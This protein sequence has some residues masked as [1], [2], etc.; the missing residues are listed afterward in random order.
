MRLKGI[1][2]S[3]GIAIAPAFVY[4]AVDLIVRRRRAQDSAAEWA[5]FE[6]AASTALRELASLRARAT[7]EVGEAEAA[8]F[9]AHEMILRDPEL[10]G[11]L[12]AEL[13]HGASIEAAVEVVFAQDVATFE[14]MED[15]LFRERAADFADVGR[16]VLRILLGINEDPLSGMNAPAVIVAQDLLP[17]DT[18]RLNKFLTRGFCTAAGGPLSHTAILARNLG[19]PAVVGVGSAVLEIGDGQQLIADGSEG[20][21]VVEASEAE[22]AAYLARLSDMAAARR[23]ALANALA[24]AITR[25][26]RRAEVV[27]NVGFPGDERSALDCGAEGIGLLRTEVLFVGRQTAPSEDEQFRAYHEVFSAMGSLP[28]VARTL[29]IG[30]DKPA[31]FLSLPHEENPFLGWR[32]IRIGLARPDLLKTQIRA[33]LRAGNEHTLKI[34][35]PMIATIEE[36]Q[37]ARALVGEARTELAQRGM[38]AAEAVEIGT[39]VEIPSAALMAEELIPHV[40]FFSIG[41]NDLTQYTLAADRG[42]PAVASLSDS[43]HPAVLRLI[44]HVIRVAHNHGIWV[45]LCGELAGDPSAIP[46]LL[47]LGLDEFS[48]GAAAIPAAKSLIRELAWAETQALA[49]EALAQSGA[50]AVRA[51]VQQWRER[52][53]SV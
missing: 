15:P 51:L 12:R 27:A 36:M 22:Q 20:W 32:A 19:L 41:S 49:R 29:D 45:G 46:I 43:L 9:D 21:V 14:A 7:A 1:A 25:D 42:N 2:A 37:A 10:E 53:P 17:S 3:P 30:G 13:E 8:V 28:V 26:G 11:S 31:P 6:R 16:R 23:T 35:F 40:D 4:R 38:P 52:Q 18:A 24:P 39:M 5:R 50:P 48:M 34:M 47:G 44:D 33:L